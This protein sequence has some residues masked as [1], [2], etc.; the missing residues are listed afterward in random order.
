MI[1]KKKE[2]KIAWGKQR[3]ENCE[4]GKEQKSHPPDLT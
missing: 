4:G 1:K 3:T 2:K